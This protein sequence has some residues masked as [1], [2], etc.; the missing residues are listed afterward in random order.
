MGREGAHQLGS[1][2]NMGRGRGLT[3]SVLV[4]ESVVVLEQVEIGGVEQGLELGQLDS[5]AA[6]A[7]TS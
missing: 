3:C 7:W 2:H 1:G 4:L 6:G 5:L